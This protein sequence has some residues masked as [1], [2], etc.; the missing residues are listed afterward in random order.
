MTREQAEQEDHVMQSPRCGAV[1]ER[2][3]C[4]ECGF[5]VLQIILKEKAN[6]VKED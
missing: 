4:P 3:P 2:W 6:Q 5:P 1:V